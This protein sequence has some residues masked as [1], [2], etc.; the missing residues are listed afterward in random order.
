MTTPSDR[1]RT[2]PE[3][4][5]IVIRQEVILPVGW[6]RPPAPAYPETV[7]PGPP[8]PERALTKSVAAPAIAAATSNTAF[9]GSH[10]I[11]EP[12]F[13][14][15]APVN[16]SN[17]I[18]VTG[19]SNSAGTGAVELVLKVFA[20]DPT[21]VGHPA[22]YV[23]VKSV[24]A[25]NGTT[26][27][28]D[29]RVSDVPIASSSGTNFLVVWARFVGGLC[30]LASMH[31]FEPLV[32]SGT[33]LR[34]RQTPSEAE[35][36]TAQEAAPPRRFEVEMLASE[37]SDG[38]R[39]SLDFDEYCSTPEHPVWRNLRDPRQFDCTFKVT[40]YG[41]RLIA[42]MIRRDSTG[43]SVWLSSNFLFDRDNELH[44]EQSYRGGNG[45]RVVVRPG[46]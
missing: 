11:S 36:R 17:Q 20:S 46:A 45:V 19:S 33:T 10:S 4:R 28:L 37:T 38:V 12:P 26:L 42:A 39:F 41:K 7:T 21:P 18:A 9:Y 44:S 8:D 5:S 29:W 40:R 22:D 43:D 16:S 2:A 1:S 30:Y 25:G 3:A 34:L 15:Q 6:D 32:S 35:E 13:G 27:P 24:K 23:G 31:P 14:G